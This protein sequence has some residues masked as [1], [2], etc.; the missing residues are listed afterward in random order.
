MISA[1]GKPSCL[2]E[3]GRVLVS[4]HVEPVVMQRRPWSVGS[5]MATAGVFY[6]GTHAFVVMLAALR[7]HCHCRWVAQ[8]RPAFGPGLV[9]IAAAAAL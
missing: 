4:L 1:G 8:T 9:L 2:N 5:Y 7:G 6:V 3:R